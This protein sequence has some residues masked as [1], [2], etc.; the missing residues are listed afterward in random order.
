M[1]HVSSITRKRLS[2]RAFER[3]EKA[4]GGVEELKQHLA[5]LQ[6]LGKKVQAEL[7]VNKQ[8]QENQQSSLTK[9]R[10][11]NAMLHDRIQDLEAV[12]QEHEQA[13]DDSSSKVLH[14]NL[15][16]CRCA[17]SDECVPVSFNS[18]VSAVLESKVSLC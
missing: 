18:Y 2:T 3:L 4:Q 17:V 5:T 7:D 1:Q 14:P 11:Q 10:H 8:E 9:C 12:I 6:A 13:A 16:H 15:P